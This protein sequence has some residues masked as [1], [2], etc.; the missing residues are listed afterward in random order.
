ML[1]FAQGAGAQW[2]RMSLPRFT[3]PGSYGCVQ[4][5]N[6]WLWV[7]RHELFSSPDT[8]RTWVS[9]NLTLEPGDVIH[10]IRFFD[11]L[12]GFVST[13]NTGIYVTS[14]AGTTWKKTF[15]IPSCWNIAYGPNS[16]ILYTLCTINCNFYISKNS[17]AT[18]NSINLGGQ[19]GL[20]LTVA[21]SG[22]IY[23]FVTHD[24]NG[25]TQGWI[26]SSTDQGSTWLK[27]TGLIDGDCFVLAVD[28]CDS[29]KLYLMN[30]DYYSTLDNESNVYLTTDEGNSWKAFTHDAYPA[31]NGG[32]ALTTGTIYIPTDR[33]TTLRSTDKGVTWKSLTSPFHAP[34]SRDNCLH[35]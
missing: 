3:V 5:Q 4:F 20:C 22:K 15:S 12:N 31:A 6:G 35:Q 29:N 19:Y 7:G 27:H 1:L 24:Y 33:G 13:S 16:S 28:S 9:S 25:A 30:E 11:H 18:W 23:A 17:G 26:M 34:D 21:K 14:D 32:A 8:G 10:D 2:K